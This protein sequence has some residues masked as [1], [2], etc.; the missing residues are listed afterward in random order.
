MYT[1]H[2]TEAVCCSSQVCCLVP[3]EERLARAIKAVEKAVDDD[4]AITAL[5]AE[6]KKTRYLE[7][8]L[9]GAPIRSV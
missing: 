9:L 8:P 6:Q 5:L 7:S 1:L 4:D 2:V 3:T